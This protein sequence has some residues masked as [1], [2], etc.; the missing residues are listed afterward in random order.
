MLAAIGLDI[1]DGKRCFCTADNRCCDF[2]TKTI[3]WYSKNSGL[4]AA[5]ERQQAVFNLRGIN[6]FAAANNHV[7]YPIADNQYALGI[8][9]T[10]ITGFKLPLEKV[11]AGTVTAYIRLNAGRRLNPNLPW[12][13]IGY[14][15]TGFVAKTAFDNRAEKT[16]RAGKLTH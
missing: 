3:V 5:V 16:R 2:F 14:R 13:A 12:L 11:I 7:F 6:I 1:C 9:I 4:L 8:E 10:H 15:L